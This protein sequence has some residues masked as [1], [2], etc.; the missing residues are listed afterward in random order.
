MQIERMGRSGQIYRY[1]IAGDT[2]TEQ[3]LQDFSNIVET[4]FND[5]FNLGPTSEE[6]SV[7]ENLK[8][9]LS[10]GIDSFN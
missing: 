1:N 8:N 4:N 6:L 3:E 7:G 5:S 2:P 9:A 10:A